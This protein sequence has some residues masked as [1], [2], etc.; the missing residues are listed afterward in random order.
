[1][2]VV[3]TFQN[4]SVKKNLKD[5]LFECFV[6]MYVYM[7]LV[8]SGVQKRVLDALGLELQKLWAAMW[9]LRIKPSYSG[10]T[11]SVLQS[12]YLDSSFKNNY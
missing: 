3:E 5:L 11:V 12:S 4:I 1:M 6:N 9:I 8:H 2:F 7:C 10:R